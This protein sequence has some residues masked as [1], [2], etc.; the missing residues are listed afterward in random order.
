M[1]GVQTCALP[2]CEK[3]ITDYCHA[4]AIEAGE[5]VAAI[6]GTETI[7]NKEG[8]GELVANM[9]REYQSILLTLPSPRCSLIPPIIRHTDQRPASP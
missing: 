2:I 4:L 1:T 6:L 9:V 7:R 5:E 3:R 8:E